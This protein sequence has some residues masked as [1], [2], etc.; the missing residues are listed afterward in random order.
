[1]NN[2]HRTMN[3]RYLSFIFILSL[4][5]VKTASAD[6]NVGGTISTNTTWDLSGSPY[7]VTSTVTVPSGITLTIEPGVTVKFNQNL[8]L[9]VN[10]TLNAQGTSGSHITFTS[11]QATP[12]A[13]Y[14]SQV[15]LN[16]AGS[17]ASQLSYCTIQYSQ[18]GLYLENSSP[19]LLTQL[20]LSNNYYG[21]YLQGSSSPTVTNS[22]MINNS[23]YGV[24]IYRSS[25]PDPNPVIHQSSL[26]GNG[27]YEVVLGGTFTNPN[28]IFNFKNNWWGTTNTQTI[29]S[30]IYDDY[31]SSA[32]PLIDYIPFLDGENGN[33]ALI[34]YDLSVDP[35]VFDPSLGETIAIHYAI[36]LGAAITINLYDGETHALVRALVASE[37][38][39]SGG[40]SEVWDG[41]NEAGDI[42]P[43]EAY[44]FTIQ[45]SGDAG[46]NVAF[47]DPASP[48]MGPT[49]AT[50]NASVDASNF[51]PYQNIPVVIQ[52]SFDVP[53]RMTIQ[54]WT[55]GN[56]V[57]RNLFNNEVRPAGVNI[58]YWDGRKDDGTIYTGNFDV[59]FGV[60]QAIPLYPL[61][62]KQSPL[63]VTGSFKTEAY[64]ILPIFSEISVVQYALS[65]EA[66]VTVEIQDPNG[67]HFKTLTQSQLQAAGPHAVEW[68]GKD[69]SGRVAF[70]E[71][72]YRVLLTV[73][74][75][76]GGNV[77][78][79][80]GTI[81]VHR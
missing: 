46:Q 76:G 38:R 28:A 48:L 65:R 64:L 19:A 7:I 71:G 55:T 12:T 32:L 37:P 45:A 77:L 23:N 42:A 49:P 58:E 54:I 80:T 30:K 11:N 9:N 50:T 68:N 66:V 63:I 33:P 69:D 27:S 75:P 53:G 52:Y 1:M 2:E 78:T 20:T 25:D 72:V 81:A 16:G 29:N 13:G 34:I 74:D 15:Y 59:Y 18:Y 61:I 36:S 3:K 41:R 10:G 14:W 47:N 5:C 79:Q 6:T 17:N 57:I 44:Y 4:L 56:Q 40:N 43:A 8:S 35:P 21:L 22:K 51:N 73:Q 39:N 60:P 24:Y 31:D 70:V 67:S 26:Y 62:I